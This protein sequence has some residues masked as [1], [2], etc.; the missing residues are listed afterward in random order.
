MKSGIVAG[1]ETHEFD[2]IICATGFDAMTGSVMRMNI[3]GADG[4]TIQKKWADGPRSY[5][6]VTIAGFPNMFNL[7]GPGSPS[8]LITMVT[9]SEQHGDFVADCMTWMKEKNLSRVAADARAEQAWGEEINS[10]A[11]R[12]LRLNCNSWHLGTNIPGKP[13][14]FMPYIGGYPRYTEILSEMV[15]GGYEGFRFA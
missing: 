9:A 15:A 3:T 2:I 10:L 5:L 1:D 4:L 8:V 14:Q 6:G 7:V 11:S 13:K 12:T